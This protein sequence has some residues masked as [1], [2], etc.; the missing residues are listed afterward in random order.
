M[1][2]QKDKQIRKCIVT[3]QHF[4]KADM[5]RIVSFQGEK[6]QIDLTGKKPGRGCYVS[7]NIENLEKLIDRNGAV[8][9]RALKKQITTEEIEYLKT[10][11]PK[12]IEEKSFRPRST[13]PVVVRIDRDK[14][15]EIKDN[16]SK[17]L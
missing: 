10:E 4:N 3:N 5:I 1:N 7:T 17:I 14:L 16:S 12:A 13:K 8:L 11:F 15:K 2:K 6:V 9:A